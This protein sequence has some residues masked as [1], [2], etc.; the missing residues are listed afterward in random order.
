MD[1]KKAREIAQ[2]MAKMIEDDRGMCKGRG[3]RCVFQKVYQS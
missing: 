2:G 1:K 3:Q